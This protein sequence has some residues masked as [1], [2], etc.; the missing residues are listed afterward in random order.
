MFWVRKRNV[1]LRRLFYAPKAYVLKNKKHM[2]KPFLG[3]IYF[4]INRTEISSPEDFGY[5]RFYCITFQL[6]LVLSYAQLPGTCQH[7]TFWPGLHSGFSTVPSISGMD[8][9]HSTHQ[10]RKYFLRTL[11][12]STQLLCGYYAVF[13]C[14]THCSVEIS[15]FCKKHCIV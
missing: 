11:L 4:P 10:S 13:K 5:T 7:V 14:I 12:N 9:T 3:V 1:S 6:E 2:I 8:Q 15:R